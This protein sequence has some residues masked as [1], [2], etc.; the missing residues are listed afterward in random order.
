[1]I[2]PG[3]QSTGQSTPLLRATWVGVCKANKMGKCLMGFEAILLHGDKIVFAQA[4]SAMCP[5]PTFCQG[6]FVRMS[7]WFAF[8]PSPKAH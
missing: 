5:M 2:I 3:I 4:V 8:A 6:L 7:V 1:M